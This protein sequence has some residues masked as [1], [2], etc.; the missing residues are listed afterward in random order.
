[1]FVHRFCSAIA[2]S[3]L[4]LPIHASI[5]LALTPPEIVNIAKKSV[6]RI[7]G[8]GPGTGFIVKKSG[9]TYTILTNAHVLNESGNYQVLAPDGRSYQLSG[10]RLFPNN[11]DLAEAEFTSDIDY[12]VAEL[13]SRQSLGVGSS[14]YSYGWNKSSV[15]IVDRT[16]QLL[17]GHI[18]SIKSGQTYRGYNLIYTLSRV[19]G[20]SG[21]PIYNDEGKVVGVY[22]LE[23]RQTT[24]T[25]GISIDTYNRGKTSQYPANRTSSPASYSNVSDSGL[26]S[27]NPVTIVEI[28]IANRGSIIIEVDVINK[29]I[30]AG[31][32]IDLT[33]KGSYNNL[34]FS[35]KLSFPRE[36][37]VQHEGC[38]RIN[39]IEPDEAKRGAIQILEN[40][41]TNVSGASSESYFSIAYSLNGKCTEFGRVIRGSD[42]IKDI[43]GGDRI[44]NIRVISGLQYLQR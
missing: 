4:T 27:L 2:I 17:Q 14:I 16:P 36:W 8:A 38:N 42:T 31:D 5:L 30:I 43:R 1:M 39:G 13:G 24:L 3:V 12:Q 44:S 23:D 40:E 7:D 32:F 28:T 10:K 19:P 29:P 34:T 26:L 21:S 33:L 15:A 22:G 6:V 20:M 35:D 37:K 11:I 9:N 25:L 41:V 18:S